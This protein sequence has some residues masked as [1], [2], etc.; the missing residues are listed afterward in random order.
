MLLAGAW[1]FLSL[2]GE[3]GVGACGIAAN[4]VGG[5]TQNASAVVART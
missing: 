5:R 1:L 3:L 4:P 2:V